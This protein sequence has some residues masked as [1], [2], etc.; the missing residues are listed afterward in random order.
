[1]TLPFLVGTVC[2]RRTLTLIL[3]FLSFR[4]H[5]HHLQMELDSSSTHLT[6]LIRDMRDLLDDLTT[7]ADH[8]LG[9][10]VH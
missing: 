8:W 6:H 7:Q 3:I 5:S 4:Q 9:V 2:M 1:M 10:F